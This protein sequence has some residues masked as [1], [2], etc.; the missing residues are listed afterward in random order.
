MNVHI[1]TLALIENGADELRFEMALIVSVGKGSMVGVHCSFE[2]LIGLWIN[3][4]WD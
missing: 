1:L 3:R 2:G 4:V